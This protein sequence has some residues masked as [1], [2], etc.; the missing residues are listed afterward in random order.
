MIPP[1][2]LLFDTFGT[3][4]DWRGSLIAELG[5]FGAGRG[6]A[7]DWTRLVDAWRGAYVPSM[8]R[9]RRGELPWTKLDDL[10]R[11]SLDRLVAEQGIEG[12][13][14]ADRA[15]LALAW[16]R[17]DPWPDTVPGLARLKP[18]FVLAPL[19][20]GNVSLLID[21]AR[22]APLPWDAV[23]GADVFR[24][25]KPDPQTYLGACAL[26]GLQ[27]GEVMMCAAHNGDLAAARRLGL[28]TGF[29]ARP[30]EYGPGQN[31]DLAPEADWDVAVG[32]V[33]ELADRLGA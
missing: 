30:A 21:L 23:F 29:I 31:R 4:V 17:L 26:L 1:R 18:H 7:A 20:N 24:R 33:E 9:V 19:S 28:R 8:D 15:H 5:A 14:E 6:I 22:R 13:H 2:A 25:Y 16:H 3:L 12:L 32:G 11:G 27:P 10:H